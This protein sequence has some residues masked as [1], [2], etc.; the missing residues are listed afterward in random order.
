MSQ[1]IVLV[2]CEA[3]PGVSVSDQQLA[4]A[5]TSLGHR[6]EGRS[7]NGD[8]L[9]CFTAADL[10]V[11]RS[12]WDYHHDLDAFKAWLEAVE[13]SDAELCNPF[14]LVMSHL[15]KS[16]IERLGAAGIRA[17]R[18]LVTADFD[19][20][21]IG[22]WLDQH[23][24]DRVVV[25]PA[26]GASGHDVELLQR[27]ALPAAAERWRSQPDRRP[28]LVQEF[29]PQI[30]SGEYS[31]VFFAGEYSHALIRRPAADDFR[32]NSQYGGSMELNP[33][34]PLSVV[35]FAGSVLTS[36]AEPTCYAR[37]DVVAD[38]REHVVIEIEVNE[39]ALGL[40]LAP[41]SAA[42]FADAVVSWRSRAL[43]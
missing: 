36:L 13:A 26:W 35:E 10:V 27:K 21:A 38:E 34:V 3:W 9:G 32:A 42:R 33:D 20:A 31:I 5:L 28:M 19:L 30:K 2:T 39:P 23:E 11:L 22:Q 6:V 29:V 16:Y 37:I 40:H 12:N 15:H 14:G 24:F 4:D 41:G 8:E 25:K 18:T 1:H 43:R 7:W 17:P